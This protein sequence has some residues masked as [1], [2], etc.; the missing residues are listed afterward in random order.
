MESHKT[1]SSRTITFGCRS[2]WPCGLRRVSAV[3]R[4]LEFE[5]TLRHITL[6]RAPPDEWPARRWE[7]YLT[8]HNTHKRQTFMHLAGYVLLNKYFSCDK[9]K[10]NEM[11]GAHSTYG[12]GRGAYGI[13]VGRTDWKRPLLDLG[14]D[15]AI[16][17]QWIFKKWGGEA[18]TG[19]IWLRT[20]TGGGLLWMWKWSFGYRKMGVNSWPAEELL[21]SREGLC[22]MK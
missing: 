21:A 10:K 18:W 20:G 11:G 17:L 5:I 4:L 3:A 6:G 19:L 14:L 1:G 12:D 2:Q 16:I 8:T 9:I 13:L 7:L 15:V 22:S